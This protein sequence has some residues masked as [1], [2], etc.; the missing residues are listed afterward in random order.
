MSCGNLDVRGAKLPIYVTKDTK[1]N[2]ALT[3]KDS[4]GAAVDLSSY[5][6]FIFRIFTTPSDVEFDETGG[7]ITQSSN[8]IT[9]NFVVTLDSGE[10]DYQFVAV[11][12]V[13]ETEFLR[14]KIKIYDSH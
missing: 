12:S 10:Y 13:G 11:D 1:V 14:G 6:N 2:R 8:M 9:F 7:D 4:E 5:T 3:I